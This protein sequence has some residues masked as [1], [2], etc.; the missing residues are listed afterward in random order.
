MSKKNESGMVEVVLVF[1]I[2]LVVGMAGGYV[3]G[4]NK[5]DSISLKQN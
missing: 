3:I 5:K 2:A 1:V 4:N